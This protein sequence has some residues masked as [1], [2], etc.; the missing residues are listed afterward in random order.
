MEATR[1]IPCHP[2]IT[3]PLQTMSEEPE[4]ARQVHE[5]SPPE[6]H[7]GNYFARGVPCSASPPAKII[8]G[9]WSSG[10]W[11][12]YGEPVSCAITSCFLP[13]AHAEV[14]GR[15]RFGPRAFVS[16]HCLMSTALCCASLWLWGMIRRERVRDKYGLPEEPCGGASA[17]ASRRCVSW[18]CA[19]LPCFQFVPR[20][21]PSPL[22]LRPS[23]LRSSCPPVH[24]IRVAGPASQLRPASWRRLATEAGGRGSQRRSAKEARTE[25]ALLSHQHCVSCSIWLGCSLLRLSLKNSAQQLPA[26]RLQ[27][28][29][30]T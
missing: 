26:I 24:S 17:C 29:C 12:C 1:L 4:Y 14:L 22:R 18:Y 2:S 8:H 11:D 3:Q 21:R 7:A 20:L 27:G 23:P 5:T 30:V 25:A 10:L 15:T 28:N 6:A 16:I 19:S 9:R 13:V